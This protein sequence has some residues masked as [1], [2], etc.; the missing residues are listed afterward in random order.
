MLPP[1]CCGRL[2]MRTGLICQ[3]YIKLQKATVIKGLGYDTEIVYKNLWC[4]IKI[5]IAF[6][7]AG[8]PVILPFEVA[9]IA[10]AVNLKGYFVFS[11]L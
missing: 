3:C 4:C 10:E 5:N 11:F 8:F 1:G 6:Y 9:A 2:L 7:A